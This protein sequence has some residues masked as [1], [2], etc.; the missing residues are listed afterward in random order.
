MYYSCRK[1]VVFLFLTTPL[2]FISQYASA[3][4]KTESEPNNTTATATSLNT[5]QFGAGAISPTGDLDFWRRD[6][7]IGSFVF[8]L[9]DTASS[10]TSKDSL[11]SIFSND[12]SL[13][14]SDNN[15]GIDG[16]SAIAGAVATQPGN[17]FF[18][19]TESGN[20]NT[21]SAY[22]LYVS[23]VSPENQIQE[24]EPNDSFS[25]A[26]PINGEMVNGSAS[27]TD[28][29]TFKLFFSSVP[30]P[31]A[32]IVD[33]D[34]DNDQLFTQTQIEL[35]DF[36]QTTVL[37]TGTNLPSSKT[38]V[39]LFNTTGRPRPIFMRIK[40]TGNNLSKNYR[41][42]VI[43]RGT[44]FGSQACCMPDGRALDT[45]TSLCQQAGGVAQ[46]FGTLA[47]NSSCPSNNV[48]GACCSSGCSCQDLTESACLAANGRW[49][50]SGSSCATNSCSIQSFETKAAFT[51]A[52]SGQII[53]D[54]SRNPDF[55]PGTA[56]GCGSPLPNSGFCYTPQDFPSGL[57]VSSASGSSNAVGP[58]V[59]GG[60][61]YTFSSSSL[62][63]FGLGS[64]ASGSAV[65]L[66]GVHAAAL[67]FG[68]ASP[69]MMTVTVK[70]I[71]SNPPILGKFTRATDPSM[72]F[73]GFRS[74]ELIG[75]ITISDSVPS[76]ANKMFDNII[77]ANLIDSDADTIADN[78]LCGSSCSLGSVSG[79]SDN[80]QTVSNSTQE[81][82]DGDGVGSACDNCS[83]ISN[84]GLIDS[85]Q[86]GLGN[87]C[88]LCPSDKSKAV[89]GVCGCNV[90]DSDVN[91]NA[92]ID[93]QFNAEMKFRINALVSR[94]SKLKRGVSNRALTR[95]IK[96]LN[97][98][99]KTFASINSAA[100]VLSNSKKSVGQLVSDF[101]RK[102]S[103][104][105][106]TRSG[107]FTL[108]KNAAIK[109]GRKLV[110]NL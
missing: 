23:V 58:N 3:Q 46:G 76:S 10:T 54:F 37:A 17:I 73:L 106:K 24:A 70:G 44:T 18:R 6:V 89:P 4:S 2:V 16:G 95:T 60:G 34:P 41:F 78:L 11:L 7:S 50:G 98:D 97:T 29:D 33:N 96:S 81:D 31:I 92:I 68:S 105:L 63:N 72:R 109:A 103:R 74:D 14:E 85:D 55:S 35:I 13:L 38:N 21:I 49:S 66:N 82:P 30:I 45:T 71:G 32:V 79:C 22:S 25:D 1:I 40:N 59:F 83:A 53:E 77:M 65:F 102:T 39:A 87:A 67:E 64:N 19:L 57:L 52:T 80:C 88:D 28:T 101:G 48:V 47:E 94:L 69:S 90:A 99:I 107:D 15:S 9:V 56:I 110:K 5:T 51:T 93:C 75:E 61:T 8:G 26:D 12:G 84:P 104:A 86:D 91:N 43:I 20:D 42:A 100:I 36:D 108:R 27:T 62:I